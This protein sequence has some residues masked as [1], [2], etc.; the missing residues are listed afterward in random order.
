MVRDDDILVDETRFIYIF[1]EM[2]KNWLPRYFEEW[3]WKVLGEWIKPSGVAGGKNDAFHILAVI[4]FIPFGEL[5]KAFA[6]WGVWL[7]AK[8]ALEWSGVGIGH[9]YIA[10]LHRNEFFV[11]FKVVVFW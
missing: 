9:W 7:K 5:A 10:R 8:V 2:I 1:D 6:K 11:G 4:L 3:F